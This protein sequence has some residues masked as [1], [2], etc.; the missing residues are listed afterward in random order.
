MQHPLKQPTTKSRVLKSVLI[1]FLAYL[2]V[3]VLWLQVKETYGYGVTLVASKV[4]AE[5][6][7][8]QLEEITKDRNVI[9]ASFRPSKGEKDFLVNL[10]V[11]IDA[12]AANLPLILSVLVALAP[13][14]K[15]RKRAYSEA[16]LLLILFHLFYVFSGE[17]LQLTNVFM[18]KGVEKESLIRLSLYHF[19]WGVTEYASMSVVPFL[20]VTYIFV[21]FRQ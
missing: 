10:P 16:L 17:M 18:A 21:R 6:K 11:R 1:F 13:F 19:L 2:V 15:R 12:Y 14:L 8:A 9:K 7:D 4:V 3:L 5:V 20:L